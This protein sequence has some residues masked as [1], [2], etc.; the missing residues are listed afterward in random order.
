MLGLKV[1]GLIYLIFTC[2]RGVLPMKYLGI[3]ADEK[4]LKNSDWILLLTRWKREWGVGEVGYLII[5]QEEP[6]GAP[7]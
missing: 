4:I 7:W 6:R 5:L 1:K 2:G 3:P